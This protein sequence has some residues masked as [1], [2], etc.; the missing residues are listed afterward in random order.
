MISVLY[1]G[2]GG[3]FYFV[4]SLITILGRRRHKVAYGAGKNNEI[5][6]EVSAH[7]N[8]SA[9][10]PFIFL[11]LFIYEMLM[12]TSIITVHM[13]GLFIVFGRFFHAYSIL[14]AEKN[15]KFG[16]RQIGM[17]LTFVPLV[18]LSIRLIMLTKLA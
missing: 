15:L 7:N 1:I 12:P 6:R 13:Y 4:I 2:L 3:L 5:I 8:F 10:I 11:M 9:Y 18:G 17:L 14:I 16:F